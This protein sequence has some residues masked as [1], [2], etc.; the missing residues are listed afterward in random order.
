MPISLGEGRHPAVYALDEIGADE[1][2]NQLEIDRA[3][4][5]WKPYHNKLGYR[6]LEHRLTISELWVVVALLEREN[7]LGLVNWIDEMTFKSASMKDK[8]PYIMRGVV[9]SL[10]EPDGYGALLFPPISE[11]PAPNHFF[12]E[13]DTGKK[14]NTVWQAKVRAYQHFRHSGLSK[15]YYD[16][17]HFRVLTITSTKRRLNNL[18]KTTVKA[19]GD[20]YFWFTTQDNIDIWNPDKFLVPIWSVATQE[21]LHSLK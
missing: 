15:K 9:K 8:V 12:L 17:Q 11:P 20:D 3:D 13:V 2:A 16:A 4:V 19:G 18:R 14:N 6:E 1:V 7:K 10:R 21:G 5:G